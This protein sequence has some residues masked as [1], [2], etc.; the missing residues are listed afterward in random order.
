MNDEKKT[1]QCCL[2]FYQA[3]SIEIIVKSLHD[4]ALRDEKLGQLPVC[5]DG[6]S[7]PTVA[8]KWRGSP[9]QLALSVNPKDRL[10][11]ANDW[12]EEHHPSYFKEEHQAS[13]RRA[14]NRAV[15]ERTCY[16]NVFFKQPTVDELLDM[17]EHRL[18][19]LH[20]EGYK[21]GG[22][23]IDPSY[24]RLWIASW[25]VS[26]QRAVVGVSFTDKCL[27]LN[28]KMVPYN[29]ST[30]YKC[31]R[32]ITASNINSKACDHSLRCYKESEVKF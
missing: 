20:L 22:Y 15:K 23:D 7:I 18:P 9:D 17:L 25:G 6:K 28:T 3:L 27:S 21:G 29:Q 13:A 10:R 26:N 5:I 31:W 24:S 8:T 14:W 16:S 11:A 12:H 1:C 2:P 19:R 32:A 4:L 30:C